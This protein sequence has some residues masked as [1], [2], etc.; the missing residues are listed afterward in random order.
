MQP[1]LETVRMHPN[2]IVSSKDVETS[3]QR[4]AD[5][6]IYVLSVCVQIIILP[7]TDTS[8]FDIIYVP[9]REI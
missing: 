5:T 3:T 2:L 4:Y 9:H 7:L 6:Q 1:M 8:L